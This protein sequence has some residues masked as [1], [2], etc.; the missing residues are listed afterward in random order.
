MRTV[1]RYRKAIVGGTAAALSYAIPVV[2]DGLL[3][4]EVL[5]IVLAGLIG[6]GLVAAVSNAPAEPGT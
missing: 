5:G 4:S 6:S 1:A 3:A 2:D